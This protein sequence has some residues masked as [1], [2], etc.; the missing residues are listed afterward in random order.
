M[1]KAKYPPDQTEMKKPMSQ[2]CG[3]CRYCQAQQCRRHAPQKGIDGEPEWPYVI[4]CYAYWCGDWR[5][6]GDPK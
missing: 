2:N 1:T 3:N 5:P 4:L 6:K